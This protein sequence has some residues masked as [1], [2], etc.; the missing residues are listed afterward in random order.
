M[1]EIRGLDMYRAVFDALPSLVFVVDDDVKI[2][3]CNAA[4]ENLLRA[5]S[6]SVLR[7]RAGQVLHCLHATEVPEGCG[8]AEFCRDCVIRNAVG[9]ASRGNR[10]VRSRTRLEIV[11]DGAVIEIFALISAAPF[12]YR[13]KPLFL[14]VVEDI[15]EIAELRQLIPI[16]SVCKK[17]RDDTESWLRLESYFKDHW[18]VDFTHGL[19]PD[20]HKAELA[21]LHGR[22]K[23]RKQDTEKQP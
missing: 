15:S 7:K 10:V 17:V 16:C 1:D 18:D 11:R 22:S 19:C 6:I 8:R 23:D 2:Y 12:I 3:E 21:K 4:A 5:K 13:G 9:D 20:C 14:L